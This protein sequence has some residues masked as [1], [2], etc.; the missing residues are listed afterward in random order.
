MSSSSLVI[1]YLCHQYLHAL[2]VNFGVLSNEF[3]VQLFYGTYA[4][5]V[6]K[7]KRKQEEF[8]N[9]QQCVFFVTRTPTKSWSSN[10]KKIV[11]K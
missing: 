4:G 8:R 1:K 7:D 6:K 10:L 2:R 3:C 5:V 11:C 9:F